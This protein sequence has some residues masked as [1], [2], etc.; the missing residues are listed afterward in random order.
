MLVEKYEEEHS[1][2][3]LECLEKLVAQLTDKKEVDMLVKQKFF[4]L[5]RYTIRVIV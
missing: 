5:N 3:I 4:T 2:Y 1:F